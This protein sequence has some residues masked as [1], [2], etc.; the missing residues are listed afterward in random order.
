MI[1]SGLFFIPKCPPTHTEHYSVVFRGYYMCSL[2]GIK[3][4]PVT[5][6]EAVVNTVLVYS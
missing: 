3:M 1:S 5:H 6:F 2:D 4:D